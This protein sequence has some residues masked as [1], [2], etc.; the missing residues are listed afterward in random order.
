MLLLRFEFW[1]AWCWCALQAS[2]P[3]VGLRRRP[4]HAYA[5]SGCHPPCSNP[6]PRMSAHHV[7]TQ[8]PIPEPILPAS[9][10]PRAPEPEP[11]LAGPNVMNVVMVGAE[12]APWS[13]TGVCDSM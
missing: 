1:H 5:C 9:L 13:K 2:L 8:V 3:F 10:P 12:C 11:P 7:H 4:Q 6:A